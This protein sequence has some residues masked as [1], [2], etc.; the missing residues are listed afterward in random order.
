MKYPGYNVDI[1]GVTPRILFQIDKCALIT[2]SYRCQEVKM[3]EAAVDGSRGRLLHNEQFAPFYGSVAFENAS[4]LHA[5]LCEAKSGRRGGSSARCFA[6][7]P[8]TMTF[9]QL[10]LKKWGN[11]W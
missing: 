6:A 1:P 3:S 11:S 10:V 4:N 7:S 9:V 5:G 8:L 2:N